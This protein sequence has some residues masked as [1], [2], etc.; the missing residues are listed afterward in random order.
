MQPRSVCAADAATLDSGNSLPA[1]PF[2]SQRFFGSGSSD[3]TLTLLDGLL[4]GRYHAP[5]LADG[6]NS[7]RRYQESEGK[8]KHRSGN[9]IL[10]PLVPKLCEMPPR[11]LVLDRVSPGV[12][13]RSENDQRPAGRAQAGLQRC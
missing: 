1:Q 6:G 10:R 3:R 13:H 2:Q 7:N 5:P 4:F 9:H 12:Q 11:Q 8:R